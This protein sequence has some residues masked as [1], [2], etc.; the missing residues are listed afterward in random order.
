VTY[1]LGRELGSASVGL[2]GAALIAASPIQIYFA[3]EARAY[4]LLPLLVAV[5]L[6]GLC[7]FLR[8]SPLSPHGDDRPSVAHLNLNV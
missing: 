7:R 8:G 5:M 1:M 6:L 2:L 3:D 4:A